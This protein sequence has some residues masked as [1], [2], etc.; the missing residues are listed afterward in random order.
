MIVPLTFYGTDYKFSKKYFTQWV[1]IM[2]I[3]LLLASIYIIVVPLYQGFESFKL[4]FQGVFGSKKVDVIEGT[5]SDSE[6]IEVQLSDANNKEKWTLSGK[7]SWY[8]L[9]RYL[10]N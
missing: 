5:G 7:F 2:S 1:I 8:T 10:I 3:C 6:V 4:I 9:E